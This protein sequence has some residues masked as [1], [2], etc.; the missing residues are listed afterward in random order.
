MKNSAFKIIAI[1]SSIILSAIIASVV[2]LVV[3]AVPYFNGTSITIENVWLCYLI[4]A[5][6]AT[7][8]IMLTTYSILR[9]N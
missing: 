6:C 2:A 1:L 5:L 8:I 9:K 4:I 7:E 3:F